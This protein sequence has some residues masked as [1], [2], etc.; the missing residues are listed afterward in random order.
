MTTGNEQVNAVRGWLE[1]QPFAL[2]FLT[3]LL[4]MEEAVEQEYGHEIMMTFM[5]EI[6]PAMRHLPELEGKES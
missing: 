5:N 6:K 1:R 2:R 4:F 3:L